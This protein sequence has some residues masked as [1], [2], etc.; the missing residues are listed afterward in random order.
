MVIVFTL[1]LVFPSLLVIPSNSHSKG[2]QTILN[3]GYGTKS[4]GISW[5]IILD[6]VNSMMALLLST[7]R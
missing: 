7:G 3:Y 1:A 5:D 6:K 4:M 2:L